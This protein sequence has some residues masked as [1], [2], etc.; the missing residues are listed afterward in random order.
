M[1]T[2]Q[3]KT[4]D[5][6][7]RRDFGAVIGDTFI[8]ARRHFKPLL[9]SII[10]IAGPFML[11][12]A[13]YTGISQVN[14]MDMRASEGYFSSVMLNSIISNLFMML[15]M[16]LLIAVIHAYVKIDIEKKTEDEIKPDQVWQEVKQS[17]W[18][19]LGIILLYIVAF[20]IMAGLFALIFYTGGPV[21]FGFTIFIS[22]FIILYLAFR[23]SFVYAAGLLDD[24]STV[25]S[26]SRSWYMSDGYFWNNV[27]IMFIFG[28]LLGAISSIASIPAVVFTVVGA[29]HGANADINPIW[30]FIVIAIQTV[31]TFI[32]LTGYALPF[33]A[34]ILQYFS[35]VE[36]TEGIG[37]L[38][39]IEGMDLK[40]E[41]NT[42]WGE[43]TY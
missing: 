26:F 31:G 38:Q 32:A 5:I 18:K 4:F 21:V 36:K 24:Y 11:L 7:K 37:L 2:N 3:L 30:K 17:I 10:I 43:E 25:N 6:R 22:I 16:V 13:I 35:A 27:G 39:R 8:Y 29:M 19:S 34:Y 28:M 23:F 9:R 20:G 1:Q 41:D 42:R 40:T 12:A 15:S 14:I 33:I